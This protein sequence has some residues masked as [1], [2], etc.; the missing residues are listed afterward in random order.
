M[1]IRVSEE[2]EPQTQASEQL[3]GAYQILNYNQQ[4]IQFADSKASSLI[5]INSLFIAAAQSGA[6]SGLL[7]RL[8]QGFLLAVAGLALLLCLFVIMSQSAGLPRLPRRDF[9]FFHDIVEKRKSDRYAHEYMVSGVTQRTEDAL[10]RTYV[11][12][13]IARHK[14]AAYTWA[15]RVTALAA[16]VWLSHSGL[17]ILLG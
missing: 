3:A 17:R 1:N 9:I 8:S 10:R 12:A 5:V 4:L 2:L 7:L 14:F 13:L 15:Q 16:L 11:L 6:S